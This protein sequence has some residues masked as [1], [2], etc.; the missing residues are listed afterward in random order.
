MQ[1]VIDTLNVEIARLHKT[2]RNMKARVP[3]DGE[4]ER[5]HERIVEFE[6]NI[7]ELRKAIGVLKEYVRS[8]STGSQYQSR[9]ME[10]PPPK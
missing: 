8:S 6:G 7:R 3:S 1:Y 4:E 5:I 9:Y 2:I 10:P